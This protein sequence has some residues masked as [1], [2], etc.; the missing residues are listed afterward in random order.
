MRAGLKELAQILPAFPGHSV[1]P[2]EEPGLAGNATNYEV[3]RDKGGPPPARDA[4]PDWLEE[5]RQR[6]QEE[7][8]ERR[9]FKDHGMEM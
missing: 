1:Q 9:K 8:R 5:A 7:T 3:V 6:A 4:A 2:V